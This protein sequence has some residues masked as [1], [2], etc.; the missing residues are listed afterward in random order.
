MDI[1]CRAQGGNQERGNFFRET[2]KGAHEDLGTDF[3]RDVGGLRRSQGE[4]FWSRLCYLQCID[5]RGEWSKGFDDFSDRDA[6]VVCLVQYSHQ[7]VDDEAGK[8]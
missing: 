2:S 7:F 3:G 1:D 8:V 4:I 5:T 6:H